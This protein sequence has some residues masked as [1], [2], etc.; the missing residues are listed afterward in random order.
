MTVPSAVT[1]P[2]VA[3]YSVSTAVPRGTLL[4]R[5]LMSSALASASPTSKRAVVLSLEPTKLPAVALTMIGSPSLNMALSGTLDMNISPPSSS[6]LYFSY[7]KLSSSRTP[8]EYTLESDLL[9][10]MLWRVFP[11]F[12]VRSDRC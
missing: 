9:E 10:K 4:K 5:F 8:L 12:L 2:T 6:R 11:M 3:W 1:S 7:P